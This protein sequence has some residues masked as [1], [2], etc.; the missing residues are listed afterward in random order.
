MVEEVWSEAMPRGSWRCARQGALGGGI[1]PLKESAWAAVARGA[2]KRPTRK[3]RLG[4]ATVLSKKSV[5]T[6]QRWV[7]LRAR[8]VNFVCM[9]R[10]VELLV[11]LLVLSAGSVTAADGRSDAAARPKQS[12]A[13]AAGDVDQKR[14]LEGAAPLPPGWSLVAE[15][16][17]NQKQQS[18]MRATADKKAAAAANGVDELTAL[19]LK[20]N[21]AA[22]FRLALMYFR[23]DGVA[24]ESATAVK[25]LRKAAELGSVVAQGNLGWMYREGGDGV[26]KDTAEALKWFRMSADKGTPGSQHQL[27]WWFYR[28]DGVPKDS[29]EA[30]KWFRMAADQGNLGSQFLLGLIFSRGDGVPKDSAEAVKWF[31]MAADQ[32]DADSQSQLGWIFWRGNGV[33]KDGAEA[34]KWFRMAADQGHADAQYRLGWIF[35]Q[36]DGVPKDNAEAVKWFRMAAEQTDAHAQF[37]LGWMYREGEGVPKDSR[38]AVKWYR[39]AAEQGHIGAQSVLGSMYREAEGMAKDG[40]EAVKWYR[41]AADQGDEVSQFRLGWMFSR[42]DGV[43][44]DGIG[45][46]KWYRMAADQ[47]FA[48]AQGNLG[49]MY[50]NG[51]GVAK[52]SVEGLAWTNIAAASGNETYVKNRGLFERQLGPQATL[53]A[54]QRSKEILKEIEAAKKS[55]SAPTPKAPTAPSE[56]VAEAPKFSGSGTIVS[57]AGHVL[58][59]AHVVAGAKSVKVI[60]ARGTT[61]AKVLRIDEA[62]DLAV[63]K[64]AGGS[65]PALSV[66]ASRTVRLGQTVATIGFPNIEIQGFSPKVTRGEISSL[67]GIG[68]DPR[69]WQISVPVQTGN[70]GGPLLDENGN[71][72]GVVV[73]KLGMAAARATG[74]LPQNVSYAV[75]SAY[76]LALLE[77]YLDGGA[78]EAKPAGA[79]LRFEDMVAKAQQSAVLILVY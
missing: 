43:P 40:A 29:A 78:V 25:W 3:Y 5:E 64:L 58:T 12:G 69:A 33:P 46:V 76:A 37:S 57:A 68:D 31:R 36:G 56:P 55:A 39:R 11:A 45:A 73:A 66:A 26:A 35:S 42:G 22:A 17:V 14:P 71:L 44:K 60:T 21:A 49:V 53:A 77:P 79:K 65:Y 2:G 74:D 18:E 59:A 50:S 61:T 27:G 34:V 63:L 38:E 7:D 8:F 51:E 19:T 41:M 67:N 75:K 23:G 9:F 52:D 13:A 70:S 15:G 32:G 30:V 54:Q 20:G 6:R 62:N 48:L 10:P 16:D 28:G 4:R 24:Q 1:R 47:G 72:V